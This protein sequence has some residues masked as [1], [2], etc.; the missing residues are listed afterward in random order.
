MGGFLL[1]RIGKPRTM[2]AGKQTT[3]LVQHSDLSAAISTVRVTE[4]INHGLSPPNRHGFHTTGNRCSRLVQPSP[5]GRLRYFK[6]TPCRSISTLLAA[7]RSPSCFQAHENR[8]GDRKQPR[9]CQSSTSMNRQLS[10]VVFPP[11]A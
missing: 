7:T 5:Y 4:Q 9:R 8:R 6:I 11:P 2:T 1:A 3:G 10:T